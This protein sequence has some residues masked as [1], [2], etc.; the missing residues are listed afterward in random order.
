MDLFEGSANLEPAE[1]IV[2]LVLRNGTICTQCAL[3]VLLLLFSQE[4][5]IG[6]RARKQEER[7]AGKDNGKQSF[8]Q[9]EISYQSLHSKVA[10]KT[11]NKNED[12]APAMLAADAFHVRDGSS[13]EPGEGASQ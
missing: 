6:R 2:L 9:T 11:T 7:N 12:P 5:R 13:E 1:S 4:V 8:L 10:L 3:D